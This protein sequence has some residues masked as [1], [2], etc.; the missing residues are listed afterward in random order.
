M[1][2]D[3][4]RSQNR[5]TFDTCV[6][7]EMYESPNFADMLAWRTDMNGSEIHLCSYAS[8]EFRKKGHDINHVRGRLRKM[9]A[10]IVTKA[11]TDEMEHDAV[12]LRSECDMLHYPDNHILAYARATETTL[13]TRDRNLAEAAGLVGTRCTNPDLLPCDE[14]AR[15]V[16]SRYRGIVKA[17]MATPA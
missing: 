5:F 3:T 6:L 2:Q 8:D 12:R 1:R 9:G 4:D 10:R 16:G 7:I 13:V 14:Q 15:N 17:W 11:V